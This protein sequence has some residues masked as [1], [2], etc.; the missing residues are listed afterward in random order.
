MLV[1]Y[2]LLKES[3]R[4]MV[5][6]FEDNGRGKEKVE[7][8]PDRESVENPGYRTIPGLLFHQCM[9]HLRFRYR[10]GTIRCGRSFNGHGP[11]KSGD[12]PYIV[13]DEVAVRTINRP[14]RCRVRSYQQLRDLTLFKDVT[15]IFSVMYTWSVSCPLGA[16]Q[17]EIP[18]GNYSAR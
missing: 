1:R 10:S 14:I 8:A 16:F 11:T 9:I 4:R 2:A 7:A 12:F 15:F 18:P 17:D 13:V 6:R 3:A 5:I